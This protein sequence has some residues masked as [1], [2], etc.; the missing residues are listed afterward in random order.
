MVSERNKLTP[1]ANPRQAARMAMP[2]SEWSPPGY[3]LQTGGGETLWCSGLM[4]NG[5]EIRG[6]SESESLSM[7][8]KASSGDL[9]I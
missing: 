7:V 2:E 6:E 9:C 1:A 4:A 3:T 8:R 5:R